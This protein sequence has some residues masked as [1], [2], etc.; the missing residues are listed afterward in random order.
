MST[1]DLRIPL[2]AAAVFDVDES[3]VDRTERRE[4]VRLSGYVAVVAVVVGA[5]VFFGLVAWN[6]AMTF[7]LVALEAQLSRIGVQV[8]ASCGSAQLRRDGDD[9]DYDE[10]EV[11]GDDYD[12]F[13]DDD[14]D[15]DADHNNN[16]DDYFHGGYDN[17]KVKTSWLIYIYIY[18]YIYIHIVK[19]LR[20]RVASSRKKR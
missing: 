5:V 4:T 3:V 20:R 9:D 12:P 6:T 11:S 1:K 18:I 13:D 17:L 2:T 10:D 14:D 15:D 8:N 7:Q 19:K 16:Y